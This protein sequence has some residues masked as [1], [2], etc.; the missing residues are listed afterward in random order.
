[1]DIAFHQT[2]LL[3]IAGMITH[4]DFYQ[5]FLSVLLMPRW[6]CDRSR[7]PLLF[8]VQQETTG[9]QPPDR[10]A[11]ARLCDEFGVVHGLFDFELDGNLPCGLRNGLIHVSWH[12]T[13]SLPLPGVTD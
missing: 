9:D 5:S 6:I 13:V 11:A 12:Q 2:D 3:D 8:S 7:R 1:M 4:L 10:L